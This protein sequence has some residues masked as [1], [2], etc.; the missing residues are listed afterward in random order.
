[1]HTDTVR[2]VSLHV[3][4]G[5]ILALIGPSGCGKTTLLRSINRLIAPRSGSITIDG[6]NTATLDPV[7]LRRSI[8][9]VIQSVALFPH[10]TVAQNIGVVPQLLGWD[11][12]A[13]ATRTD[14]LLR[15]VRLDPALRDRYPA[16]LSG[17]QSQRAGVA[18]ALAARPHLMLMD[19]PFAA[20]D[21]L[22]RTALQRELF[23]AVR[24]TGTTVVIVTHDVGEA[25]TIAHRVAIMNNGEIAMCAT[26][27]E[28]LRHPAND[29]VRSLLRAG[30]ATSYDIVHRI[31][32]DD[33]TPLRALRESV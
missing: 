1:M 25:L 9:Y 4:P 12:V 17:G 26:P 2:N 13:I 31:L 33:D 30:T 7:T 29:F 32:N 18:R 27:N 23:E 20:V 14:E 21:P 11:T 22:A 16:S 8:G 10:L 3:A 5:E 24:A 28:V 15:L 19:E 6:I